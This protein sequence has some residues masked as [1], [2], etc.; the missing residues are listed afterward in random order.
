MKYVLRTLFLTALSIVTLLTPYG[1]QPTANPVFGYEVETDVAFAKG[2]VVVDGVET[3]R[4]LLLDVYTPSDSHDGAAR[5][6][7]ILVHGGAFHRGGRRQPPYR[8]AGAVHS[9]M[10]DYARLLTPLGYVCFVIEYRL[11]PELPQTN[12]QPGSANLL[13][14]DQVIESAAMERTNFAR[15]AMGLAALS[16]DERIVLWNAAMAGAEDTAKAVEFV[17]SNA[18]KYGVNPGK[19]AVGGHSA[20]GGNVMNVA[21][22]L[23]APVAAAFPLSPPASMFNLADVIDQQEPPPM[24][25]VVS[26]NDVAATLETAPKTIAILRAAGAPAQLVWV[27][28]FAH[29]YPTGA[30]TLGDDG[31]RTSLGERVIEFLD[32]HLK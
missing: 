12:M 32:T 11:A 9:R 6:A 7:V 24:L 2:R 18:R 30:V 27:P 14:L 23:N 26:Q 5:P 10:E 29:F 22:G 13:P 25:I 28:G 16:D 1:G 4:D 17:R 20:G 3:E 19:I 21:I 15:Q 31:T 8:E